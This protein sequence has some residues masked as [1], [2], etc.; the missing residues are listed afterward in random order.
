MKK[1]ILVI[2]LVVLLVS[3]TS[4]TQNLTTKADWVQLSPEVS[5]NW[6]PTILIETPQNRTYVTNSVQLTF[7][8]EELNIWTSYRLNDGVGGRRS[9]NTQSGR[10]ADGAHKFAVHAKLVSNG[11]SETGYFT[12]QPIA[13]EPIF[14]MLR[15]YINYTITTRNGTIWATVDGNYPIYCINTETVSKVTMVYPMPPGAT[16][17]AVTLDGV[18]LTWENYT[19]QNPVARHHTI[20]GD[21][22]MIAITFNPSKFFVLTIH[23]KHP[24]MATNESYQFLYDLNISPYLS[25]S[26][27]TSTAHFTLKS[28]IEISELRVF[29]VSSEDVRKEVAFTIKDTDGSQTAKFTVTSEYGK[30]PTGGLLVK[31]SSRTQAK[32]SPSPAA[33]ITLTITLIVIGGLGVTLWH[34]KLHCSKRSF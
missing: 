14:C 23:Y 21:G 24:V 29:T 25:T 3:I 5:P 12:V 26:N 2:I 30:S 6:S 32:P 31:F 34:R 28:D 11:N 16:N 18:H 1:A 10:V 15:E 7:S 33:S 22:P 4:E 27:P 9:G 20:F 13:V 17:I 8:I 19:E